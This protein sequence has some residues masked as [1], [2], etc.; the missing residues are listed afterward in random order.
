MLNPDHFR[1]FPRGLSLSTGISTCYWQKVSFTAFPKRKDETSLNTLRVLIAN[2]QRLRLQELSNLVA[3]LG[4]D[5]VAHE[6]RPDE[7]GRLA[8][9]HDPDLALVG[10]G[11]N[12]EHALDLISNI[13]RAADCPIITVLEGA[14][15]GFVLEAAERGVFGVV[16]NDSP[17]ELQ[18][19][20]EIVL[21]RH[22]DFRNLEEAFHRRAL[23]ERAKGILMERY[24][25]NERD[26]F[27]MIRR[28]SQESGRKVSEIAAALTTAHLL[29]SRE[30][31]PLA[32]GEP[33]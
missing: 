5:V 6:V 20:I 29:L 19:A 21:H 18:S 33:V 23:I 30:R 17:E 31:T 25:I 11:D 4:H 32:E 13:V 8:S 27:E 7:V 28:R 12:D 10:V 9:G 1:S 15:T 3:D 26:A 24:G 14:D 22:A 16:N 2:E